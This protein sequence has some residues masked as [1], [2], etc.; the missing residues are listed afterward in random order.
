MWSKLRLAEGWHI[1]GILVLGG[2]GEGFMSHVNTQE[3]EAL[4]GLST[5]NKITDSTY[6]CVNI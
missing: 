6:M 5:Q 4:C 2:L 1:K 3:G